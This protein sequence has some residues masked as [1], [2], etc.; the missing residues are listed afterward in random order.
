MP[1]SQPGR[2][3]SACGPARV[4]AYPMAARTWQRAVGRSGLRYGAC[5]QSAGRSPIPVVVDPGDPRDL[6]P[7][8]K[9]SS[10]AS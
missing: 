4:A 3:A 10:E 2:K 7:R 9:P 6:W 5:R 8:K 1:T